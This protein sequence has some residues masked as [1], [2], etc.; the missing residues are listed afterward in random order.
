METASRGLGKSFF[1]IFF[2]SMEVFLMMMVAGGV[3]IAV[4]VWR[5]SNNWVS[6]FP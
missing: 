4:L 3:T 5:S 1:F 2:F 6:F